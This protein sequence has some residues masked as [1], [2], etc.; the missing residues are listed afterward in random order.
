MERKKGR[1][2]GEENTQASNFWVKSLIRIPGLKLKSSEQSMDCKTLENIPAP[3]PPPKKVMELKQP[4][5][6]QESKSLRI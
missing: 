5:E 4:Q 2:M 1:E 3:A 6:A